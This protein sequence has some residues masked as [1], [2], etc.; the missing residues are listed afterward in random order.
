MHSYGRARISFIGKK[1]FRSKPSRT[2]EGLHWGL[3]IS[4]L[5]VT[6]AAAAA[7]KRNQD[8]NDVTTAAAV[9]GVAARHTVTAAAA[10]KQQNQPQA[11]ATAH[12]A[13]AK[14]IHKFASL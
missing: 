5:V 11:A 6:A 12:T 3:C 9:A 8:G 10:A 7:A 13:F 14:V 1:T 4:E 2:G